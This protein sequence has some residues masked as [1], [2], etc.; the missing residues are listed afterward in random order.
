MPRLVVNQG[1]VVPL[2]GA[3][4]GGSAR[5]LTRRV[6]E[7]PGVFLVGP[8]LLVHIR[9]LRRA[10]YG[11]GAGIMMA[12]VAAFA[13][14][15]DFRHYDKGLTVARGLPVHISPVVGAI[16][17]LLLLDASIVGASA[18]TLTTSYAFGDMFGLGFSLHRGL[19]EAKLFYSFY[20][21]MVVL[22]AAIVLIPHAPLGLITTAVQ[23]LAGILLPSTTVFAV[24][25]C[26]DRAVLGP[27]INRPWLHAFAAIIVGVL[28]LLSFTLVISTVF[29]AVDV[30][31]LIEVLA[32][33]TFVALL[34]GG[35]VTWW[36]ARGAEPSQAGSR[37]ERENWRRPGPRPR[38]KPR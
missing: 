30:T 32:P 38:R 25:L 27:W 5:R 3:P 4:G 11:G 37:V 36:R 13:G 9:R 17:A 15:Q 21:A 16:F 28:L 1:M 19:A 33:V 7:A 22:A 26:N 6:G 34:A 20:A 14:T 12:A 24:L 10:V 29:P 35:A 18:V 23:A 2:G 8:L 31:R